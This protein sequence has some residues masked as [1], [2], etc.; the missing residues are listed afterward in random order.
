MRLEIDRLKK[1]LKIA[2][3]EIDKLKQNDKGDTVM[4]KTNNYM[5]NNTNNN[6]NSNKDNSN[7]IELLKENSRLR[8]CI[9]E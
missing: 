2:Y 7:N 4:I 8:E 3:E 5:T 1:E 9:V 6:S